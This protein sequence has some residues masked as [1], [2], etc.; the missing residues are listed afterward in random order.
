MPA[1]FNEQDEVVLPE[2]VVAYYKSFGSTPNFDRNAIRPIPNGLEMLA[3]QSVLHGGPWNFSVDPENRNGQTQI[4]IKLSFP[5]CLQVDAQNNPVLSSANNISHLS[6]AN[7]SGATSGDCPSSHPYRIPQLSY[8]VRY[9]VPFNS[10]WY[11][12]SDTSAQT[13]GQ[14]LHADYI[15]AW[16]ETS[17]NRVVQCNREMRR[18][19]QFTAY[20]DGRQITRSQLPERFLSPEGA[21][22]YQSSFMLMGDTDRTPF[23]NQLGKMK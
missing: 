11:L 20:E 22:I 7:N 9:Q 3:N 1:L 17:M 16:D 21:R 12:A 13:Q 5:T 23:G 14:S 8:N 19:C 6:Y 2:G 10:G 15:A 18:E 4:R